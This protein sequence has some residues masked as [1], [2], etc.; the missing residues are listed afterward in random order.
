MQKAQQL[1]ATAGAFDAVMGAGEGEE[2]GDHREPL[3]GRTSKLAVVS[4]LRAR[5]C[6]CAGSSADKH[7]KGAI[8]CRVL[9]EFL[10]PATSP[11]L[12]TMAAASGVAWQAVQRAP[13]PSLRRDGRFDTTTIRS[14]RSQADAR[15]APRP[16][17][18]TDPRRP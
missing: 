5:G 13:P 11:V 15:H 12:L 17:T 10:R 6:V 1:A 3:Q 9:L 7:E 8:G 2:K 4:P 16:A 18:P 14:P